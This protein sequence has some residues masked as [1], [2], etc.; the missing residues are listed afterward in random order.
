MQ[1]IDGKNTAE[2]LKKELAIEV[3]SAK[4]KDSKRLILQLFW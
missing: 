2:L 1:L 3:A 4:K